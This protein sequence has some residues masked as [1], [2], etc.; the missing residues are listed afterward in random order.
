MVPP[1]TV[2]LLKNEFCPKF[3]FFSY[4]HNLVLLNYHKYEKDRCDVIQTGNRIVLSLRLWSGGASTNFRFTLTISACFIRAKTTMS[5]VYKTYSLAEMANFI[6]NIYLKCTVVY[7]FC[8]VI[9]YCSCIT[10][11]LKSGRWAMKTRMPKGNERFL[12]F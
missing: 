5:G 7:P 9:I 8:N 12:P 1:I 10:A 6:N 11:S 4:S 3:A 2:I